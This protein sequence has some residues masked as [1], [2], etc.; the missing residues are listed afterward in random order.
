M[1]IRTINVS[2]LLNAIK[3][4]ISGNLWE[5]MWFVY[6]I[7]GIYLIHP[8]FMNLA[9]KLLKVDVLSG[10]LYF[11]LFV[12]AFVLFAISFITTYILKRIPLIKK[13]F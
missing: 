13:L 8:F 9:I 7:I 6:S 12:F 3:S 2:V 4:V 10:N 1:A 5:H 11:K